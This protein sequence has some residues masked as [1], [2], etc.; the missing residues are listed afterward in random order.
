MRQPHGQN[1]LTNKA[2]ARDIVEAAELTATDRVIEIGPGRGVLTELIAP[3]VKELTVIEIDRTLIPGLEARFKKSGTVHIINQDFMRF[4]LDPLAA[5][6][7]PV[8]VISNLPYN[9]ATPILQRILPWNGW[10]SAVVMVQREV[11][12]RMVASSGTGEYGYFSLFCQYYAQ[13]ETVMRVG[14]GSFSPPPKVDSIVLKLTNAFPPAPAPS[15]FPIIKKAFSQRRKTIANALSSGIDC[16]KAT[17][18]ALLEQAHIDPQLRPER[19][20]LSLYQTL[21]SLLEKYI[22]A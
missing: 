14:P 11:G 1:F 12:E 9:V 5:T 18:I 7:S 10:Q 22:I 13:V 21:T 15:L 3:Q 2:V 16:P 4:T 8:K 19:L 20:D 6:F 17:V